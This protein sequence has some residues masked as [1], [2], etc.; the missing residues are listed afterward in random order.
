MFPPNVY[1]NL[2]QQIKKKTPSQKGHFFFSHT[3]SQQHKGQLPASEQR[4]ATH[5]IPACRHAWEAI[6]GESNWVL[7]MINQVYSLHFGH[8][9]DSLCG[10]W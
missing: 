2:L 9:G 6:P 1:N 4:P 7:D 3:L 10:Q 5:S 8:S